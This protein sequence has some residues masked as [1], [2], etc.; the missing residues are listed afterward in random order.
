[1]ALEELALKGPMS[2][3]EKVL[4]VIFTGALT[5]WATSS[6]TG[7]D[8]AFVALL[9]LSVIL[10]T[11]VLTWEDVLEEKGAW[12]VLIWIGV[13]VNMAAY[14]VYLVSGPSINL[15]RYR[16]SMDEDYWYL[17]KN[18]KEKYLITYKGEEFYAFR[19]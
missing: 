6:I 13:L 10:I 5:L 8:S 1:M 12:D 18:N 14:W 19:T 7:L 4:L 11:N 17:V 15:D 2:A 16:Y 3:A 9:G